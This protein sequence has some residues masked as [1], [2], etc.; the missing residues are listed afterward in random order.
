MR[1]VLLLI[2]FI[3]MAVLFAGC[4]KEKTQAEGDVKT[5]TV[6]ENI[7]TGMI[8]QVIEKERAKSCC[9]QRYSEQHANILL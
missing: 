7:E 2:T 4:T 1:R 6:I 9:I 3:I 5:E 8:P